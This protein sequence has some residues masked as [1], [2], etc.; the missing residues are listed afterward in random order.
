MK[1]AHNIEIRVF[2]REDENIKPE[3]IQHTFAKIMPFDIDNEK[4]PD[5]KTQKTSGFNEMPIFVYTMRLEKDRHC[6]DF[7]ENLNKRLSS[8]DKNK[9]SKQ[10]DSR[11]DN[12][13]NFYLRLSRNKLFED[14][15]ELTESGECFHIRISLAAFPKK[16]ENAHNII[17]NIFKE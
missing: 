10:M 6:N 9:I 14:T 2:A 1:L 15:Y 12:N 16:R 11:T 5:I 17:N 13:L 8:E 4:T 3:K 7:L